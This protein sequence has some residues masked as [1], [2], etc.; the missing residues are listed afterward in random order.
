MNYPI[1]QFSKF[2]HFFNEFKV[3]VK[4]VPLVPLMVQVA[5]TYRYTETMETN[6]KYYKNLPNLV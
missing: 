2:I 3:N 6:L 5:D 4:F 1:F